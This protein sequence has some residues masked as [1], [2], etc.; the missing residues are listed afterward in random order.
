MSSEA[1][2]N[3]SAGPMKGPATIRVWDPLVRLF[4]WTVAAGC[5]VNGLELIH[6]KTVHEYIG[7]AVLAALAVRVVWGFVGTKYARFANF[8]R[9]PRA[10]IVYTRAVLNDSEPRHIGHNPLAALMILT[11]MTLILGLGA[12]G[13]MMGLDAFWGEAWL[14]ALHG[15]M[16]NTLLALVVIHA[17]A[18]IY[19]SIKHRENLI[20]SM[21]TGTKRP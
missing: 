18:A 19:E 21:I 2:T 6:N 3:V 12:T 16:A 1:E 5:L 7:Y 4:H 9:G 17:G 8:L 20:W 13:W 10:T 11:L 14:E 15:F